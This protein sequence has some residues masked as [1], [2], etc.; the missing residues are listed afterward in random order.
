MVPPL[1]YAGFVGVVALMRAVFGASWEIAIVVLN[2]IAAAAA[3]SI[4]AGIVERATHSKGAIV[5][6]VML[7]IGALD[8][9]MWIPMVVSDVTYMLLVVSL[10]AS[11]V[12]G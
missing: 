3:V 5:A 9:L 1:T 10:F 12:R 6:A 7:C 4:V 11:C 2:V 8:I